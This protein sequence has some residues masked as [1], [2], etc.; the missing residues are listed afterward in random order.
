MH[1]FR[2]RPWIWTRKLTSQS[3]LRIVTT[4]WEKWALGS[5]AERLRTRTTNLLLC[6]M[7]ANL[8]RPS[9][10]WKGAFI[11][12]FHLPKCYLD[13]QTWAQQPFSARTHPS[14]NILTI[15]FHP[16]APSSFSIGLSSWIP[17]TMSDALLL[18]FCTTWAWYTTGKQS[19]AGDPTCTKQRPNST[20]YPKRQLRQLR[21]KALSTILLFGTTW[22][23]STPISFKLIARHSAYS[24][25]SKIGNATYLL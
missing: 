14:W 20:S 21:T 18:S 8:G 22:D 16:R 23:M 1:P 4:G 7:P 2:F 9:H 17:S 25:C 3:P 11:L 12:F 13:M 19:S 5:A 6:Y 15:V 24:H 10:A